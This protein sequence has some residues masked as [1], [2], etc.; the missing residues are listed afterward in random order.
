M[1]M[2]PTWFALLMCSSLSWAQEG[3]GGFVGDVGVMVAGNSALVRG[4]EANTRAAPYLYG[5]WGRFYARVDTFGLRTTSLGHGD[6]ELTVR[7]S[8]EGFEGGKTAYPQLGDRA[9][10]LP[11]GAGTFQ[12]TSLGGLFAYLMHDPRSGGQFAELNWAVQTRLGPVTLYP[13]LGLQYRSAA[14][15]AHLYGISDSESAT[16]GLPVWRPG[17][18]WTPQATLQAHWPLGGGWSVQAM[19]RQRGLDGAVANSPLVQRHRQTAGFLAITRT[20]N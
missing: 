5:D 12:R 3:R 16:S 2:R 13:Q 19:G 18:S 15:V 17:A 20:L 8:T 9:S 11:V 1:N 14:Y 7:V 4:A 10:P 6:L